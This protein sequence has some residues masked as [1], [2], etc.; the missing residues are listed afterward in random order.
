M[1]GGGHPHTRLGDMSTRPHSKIHPGVIFE[2]FVHQVNLFFKK[3]V[4]VRVSAECPGTRTQSTVR[5]T[6]LECYV[7]RDSVT[8]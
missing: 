1:G 4:D 8:A 2:Y 7:Q 3:S 5:G 6:V